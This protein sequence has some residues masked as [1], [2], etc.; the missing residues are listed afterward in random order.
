MTGAEMADVRIRMQV[1]NEVGDDVARVKSE[2]GGLGESTSRSLGKADTTAKSLDNTL[3]SMPRSGGRGIASISASTMKM[4]AGL[5]GAAVVGKQL[6]DGLRGSIQAADDIAKMS[7]RIGAS[8]EALSEYRYVADLSGISFQTLTMGWQ[9]MTRRI[10]EAAGG[11]GEARDALAELGLSA[12]YLNR[13]APEQQFEILADAIGSVENPAD[14]VRL[15]MRLFDSEGVAL[16]QTMERGS[17]GIRE[18]RAEAAGLGLTLSRDAATGAEEANDAI[19]RLSASWDGFK[20]TMA[21]AITPGVVASL[22]AITDFIA[23]QYNKDALFVQVKN[24]KQELRT[25]PNDAGALGALREEMFSFSGQVKDEHLPMLKEWVDRYKELTEAGERLQES[26]I[27][28]AAA[29]AGPQVLGPD[30]GQYMADY[31]TFIEGVRVR[32]EGANEVV[33]EFNAGLKRADDAFTNTQMAA[34]RQAQ[35]HMANARLAAVQANWPAPDEDISAL[36]IELDTQLTATEYK[37]ENTGATG[38][39]AMDML[40]YAGIQAADGIADAFA[41]SILNTKNGLIDLGQLGMSIFSSLLGGL[42]KLG[43]SAVLPGSGALL[44]V[45]GQR[46]SGGPVA[47]GKTYLIGERGPELLTMGSTGGYVTPNNKLAAAT[48]GPQ[49]PATIHVT[50]QIN[51]PANSVMFADNRLQMRRLA[52]HIDRVTEE[53][54]KRTYR[55]RSRS[56]G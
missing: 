48:V 39:E 45:A 29:T 32:L 54:V 30:F 50:N 21:T 23:G 41:A 42:F 8:T 34:E 28:P 15:A 53:A 27:V 13:L 6:F 3:S 52:E 24:I 35:E 17:A 47:A 16:V 4:A 46:A 1:I 26:M 18:M 25:L 14:R 5:A 7:E 43:L 11:M 49:A 51:L 37:F 10:S 33:A 19:S 38:A 31:N 20:Q 9:R 22:Q 2:I 40:Q 56:N 36:L 55:D 12:S 44:G